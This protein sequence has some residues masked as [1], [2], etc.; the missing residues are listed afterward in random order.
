MHDAEGAT[1]R[2]HEALV[3]PPRGSC[4]QG[5]PSSARERRAMLALY[6]VAG[7][8]ATLHQAYLIHAVPNNFQIFRWS[9]DNL[10]DGTDLY[11]LHP[12]QYT[13]FYKYSPTF[14]LLFAPF[15]VL[16]VAAGL[17]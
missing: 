11:A 7:L 2:I 15:S 14:A 4:A 9:F 5:A 6:V 12:E 3:D 10:R 13:D 8:V 17:W 16:P 1:D